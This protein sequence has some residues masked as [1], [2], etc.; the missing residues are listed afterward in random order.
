MAV[1]IGI[2][3][4]VISVIPDQQHSTWQKER[5]G[6]R[7][8]ASLSFIPLWPSLVAATKLKLAAMKF[9]EGGFPFWDTNANVS[10]GKFRGADIP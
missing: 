2:A 8:T 4:A 6:K 9:Q 7:R 1:C 10:K 3:D 5:P